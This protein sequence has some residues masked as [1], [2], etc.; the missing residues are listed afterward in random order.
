MPLYVFYD[1][2]LDETFE[3]I[4]K[5]DDKVKFLESNPNLKERIGAPNIVSGVDG[6]RKPDGGFDEL[7]SRIGE[8]NPHTPLGRTV[9]THS[10]RD[11][12]INQAVDRYKKRSGLG[13]VD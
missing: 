9:N 4:M 2:E 6:L 7:L 10:A 11:V 3:L 13:K 1:S 5:Y 8:A 12:K